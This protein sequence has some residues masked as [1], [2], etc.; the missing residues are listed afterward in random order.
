MARTVKQHLATHHAKS[1]SFDVG[2]A[3]EFEK[4]RKCFAALETNVDSWDEMKKAFG[5]AKDSVD[6]L[7]ALFNGH[8]QYHRDM[9]QDV[10]KSADSDDLGKLAPTGV[11]AIYDPS[12]APTGSRLVPRA[13]QRDPSTMPI[14]PQFEH[15]VRVE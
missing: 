14:D 6:R 8:A 5:A 10:E 15:L 1:A 13:G 9:G 7:G 3:S 2:I 4:L 11:S 12:K